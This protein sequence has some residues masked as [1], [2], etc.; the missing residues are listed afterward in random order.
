MLEQAFLS[1]L[2]DCLYLFRGHK[3]RSKNNELEAMY[4]IGTGDSYS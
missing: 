4:E 2:W 3:R 1:T